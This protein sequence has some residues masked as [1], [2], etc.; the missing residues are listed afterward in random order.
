M[1]Q[2]LK[3]DTFTDGQQVTGARLNQLLDASQLLVGAITEQPS[4]TANTL[5]ATDSTIVNDAGTLKEA[6]IGDILNSN[7]PISTSSITGG[8]GVDITVT[9]ASGQKMDI[10]GALEANSITST[11]DMTVAGSASFTANT[12]IKIPVGTTVERPS[13][14]VAGQLRYNSTLDQAEVYSGTEWKAVGGSPF[15]AS[16]GTETTV[17]GF[18]IH[19][20]TTSGTFTPA[21]NREGKIEY[22]IVGA[23]GTGVAWE[24]GGG[25]GGGNVL[26]GFINIPKNQTPLPVVVGVGSATDGSASSFSG[27]TANGGKAP[28][29]SGWNGGDSG[30][31][32][33]GVAGNNDGGAGGS[34]AKSA[35]HYRAYGLTRHA[36]MGGLGVG[37]SISGTYK[38]YGGGGSGAT[39]WVMTPNMYGGGGSLGATIANSGGG[40]GAGQ[41]GADGVVIIRYRVS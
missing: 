41:Q 24:K 21:L 11:G 25:G 13:T 30:S 3:G 29:G 14:P 6:T 8:A 37:S 16:G 7:L 31:G 27:F 20:F 19:T 2:I 5:E 36:G 33:A 18:K 26:S 15:D 38:E 9:P 17:D 39:G 28:V 34:G 12:A 32:I 4:I 35:Q 22:L 1:A 10:G 23:G 40:G